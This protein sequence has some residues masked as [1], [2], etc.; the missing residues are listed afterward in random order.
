M[1]KNVNKSVSLIRLIINYFTD[2]VWE[3]FLNQLLKRK[4]R[5]KSLNHYTTG[6]S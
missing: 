4:Q 6:L 2:I 1:S 5:K 3:L